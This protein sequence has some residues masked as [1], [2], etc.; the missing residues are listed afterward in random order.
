LLSDFFLFTFGLMS[1]HDSFL[2]MGSKIC[3][4]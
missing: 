2:S 3:I 4:S 1:G